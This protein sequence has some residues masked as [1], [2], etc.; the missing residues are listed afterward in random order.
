MRALRPLRSALVTLCFLLPVLAHAEGRSI[1]VL[2]ASG[3]MWGQ[4]DGRTKI[5]I[6][7]EA[8]AGVLAEMPPETEM[9][10]MAYGHRSKG[11]CGDIELLVPP[12]T[13]TGPAMSAAADA[14]QFLGKTPLT[15]AVRQAAAALRSTEEKATV[16]LITDGVE[17]CK[18]DPCA[19][20]RELEASGVDFTAHVVGFGLTAE[21]GA[22]VA[23]LAETTGGEYL[24]AGDLASLTMA[25][26]TTVIAP[27]PPDPAPAPAP[28]P[29]TMPVIKATPKPV[30]VV[31]N[32]LAPLMSL[33]EGTGPLTDDVGQSWELY[34]IVDGAKGEMVSYAYGV[35]PINVAP[36][37]Y[38]L[39]GRLGEARAE[40]PVT[41]TSDVQ[42]TPVLA[43]NATPVTFRARQAEGGPVERE[44]TFVF[45]LPDGT[46]AT[47]YVSTTGGEVKTHLPAGTI[48]MRVTLGQAA[49][50]ENLTLIAGQPIDRDVIVGAGD[51]VITGFYVEGLPV[52]TGSELVQ[53]KSA[54][55]ALTNDRDTVESKYGTS[56]T[57]TLSPGDYLAVYQIEGIDYEQPITVQ[58]GKRIE[59][60]VILNAGLLAVTAP[61]ATAIEVLRPAADG[62]RQSLVYNYVD[63]DDPILPAGDY[64]VIGHFGDT[65]VELAVTVTAGARTELAV[66]A[67]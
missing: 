30:I 58:A 40:M 11:D 57:F 25:L 17:T 5:D 37:S 12:A 48:P 55:K 29:A 38:I 43:M 59:V 45:T 67:P 7:R 41:L 65:A 13:G 9:G 36:G 39:A 44:A 53:I 35:A 61:G 60:P 3:S 21:E 22:E 24:T 62:T 33:A 16:I 52:E 32:N 18:A 6:A 23:C 51:V 56:P 34:S 19:L 66:P 50:T 2:D 54:P 8:L 47:I 63:T 28:K 26:E 49:L 46:D 10:L 20:G 1:I 14:L 15:D 27:A 64:V 42:A 31:E 4:I